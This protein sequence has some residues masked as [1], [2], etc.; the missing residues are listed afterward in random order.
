[1]KITI[2][3]NK[4]KS[5]IC[6]AL[7]SLM[8]PCMVSTSLAK[9]TLGDLVFVGDSITQGSSQGPSF[10]YAYWKSLVDN[11]YV[12]GQDYSFAG[13]QTGTYN[14][15]TTSLAGY[16]NQ[17]FNA[18]NIHEG[19]FN[20]Q[21]SW[22]AN[23]TAIGTGYGTGAQEGKDSVNYGVGSVYNWL[24]LNNPATTGDNTYLA[25]D[26]NTKDSFEKSYGENVT[27]AG[28]DTVCIML[29]TNDLSKGRTVEQLT[30][31]VESIVKAYQAANP[32]TKVYVM[33]IT[34]P[35]GGL[36]TATVNSANASFQSNASK[37]S[38]DTSSVEYY[39]ITTGM[40]SNGTFNGDNYHPSAQ[41]ELIMA[42]NVAK[43]LG[44]GQRT[45][46]QQRL[47][48][49]QF[50]SGNLVGQHQLVG[51]GWAEKTQGD[52]LY[53]DL[54]ST[55]AGDAESFSWNGLSP[56][57]FSVELSLQLYDQ[58]ANN[59]FSMAVGNG[60]QSGILNFTANTISW[61]DTLLYTHDG[62]NLNAMNDYR[63]C[64][65]L[66]DSS[67]GIS[68]G[69]YIWYNGMLIGESLSSTSTGSSYD[70]VTIG[71][72]NGG[73]SFAGIGGIAL[74]SG[75]Y[76]PDL[77]TNHFESL[78]LKGPN[79]I[80]VESLSPN[81]FGFTGSASIVNGSSGIW[82]GGSSGYYSLSG[83]FANRIGGVT[84][85]TVTGNYYVEYSGSISLTNTGIG[86]RWIS[87][88][89]GNV[90]GDLYQKF[91]ST[92]TAPGNNFGI[93][94]GSFGEKTINGNTYI[95]VTATSGLVMYGTDNSGAV[96][97]I[98]G[99]SWKGT[100]TGNSNVLLAGG[101]YGA[102]NATNVGYGAI[103]GGNST[104]GTVSGNANVTIT[105]G[106]YNS[107][108]CGA[109]YAS[110][111]TVAGNT[112]V[113]ITG[114]TFN[115]NTTANS[116]NGIYGG[117]DAGH[118]SGST[119][120]MISGE[121]GE[122][123]VIN[124]NIYGGSRN[125]GNVGKGTN[126]TIKDF[127]AESGDVLGMT[128][129]QIISGGNLAG[130]TVTGTKTLN[131]ENVKGQIASTLQQFD[132]VNISQKSTVEFTNTNNDLSGATIRVSDSSQFKISS[133]SV[134]KGYSSIVLADKA[135]LYISGSTQL[136]A[137]KLETS[138]GTRIILGNS[139][140]LTGTTP[141]IIASDLE[142]VGKTGSISSQGG[143]T[144]SGNISLTMMSTDF[145]MVD[146]VMYADYSGL[147]GSNTAFSGNNDMVLNLDALTG[148]DF[149]Q[150]TIKLFDETIAPDGWKDLNVLVG[151]NGERW[152]VDMSDY[153]TNG[154]ITLNQIPEPSSALLGI[155]GL[156]G[157]LLRRRR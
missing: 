104:A 40:P 46:G 2:K 69:F 98:F 111:T 156:S 148:V 41:G 80:K 50:E 143:V 154:T 23:S 4:G 105:G 83:T 109:G 22:I 27:Y 125:G 106:T 119:N 113:Y 58:I 132:V 11:G 138:T 18:V 121:S 147:F 155:I 84:S 48:A 103:Y 8:A 60:E 139:L 10:R 123:L 65:I 102:L 129:S 85:G 47:A 151:L 49:N 34:A 36:S 88:T 74:G 72:I 68:E 117:G 146:N 16:G 52:Q 54:N 140:S 13:S 71:N 73:N 135:S 95:E 28:G 43:M 24:G 70:G 26:N 31:D 130:G 90:T 39:D 25:W 37:W 21:A 89:S 30:A 150:V 1:M 42:G 12:Y 118:V 92:I 94:G 64:Y 19:H 141:Q 128:S 57:S 133:E 56:E 144:F 131:V 62:V 114:G 82:H 91:C 61:G 3:K 67:Q 17:D 66:G 152:K 33:S 87:G 59:Q 20:W 9:S 136:D 108:V 134:I 127:S 124:T 110:T 100:I 29:G 122:K 145:S 44:T 55:Q 99:G 86:N 149:N 101:T 96:G 77:E 6:M 93:L 45:V 112:N 115:V 107:W 81:S 79:V 97:A 15:S 51:N 137:S 116:K 14:N 153:Q 63:V 126:I 5:F 53:W 142:F 78:V 75:T 157:L 76:A 35:K 38:T 32:N 7:M 120:V